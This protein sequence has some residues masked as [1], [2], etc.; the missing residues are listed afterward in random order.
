MIKKLIQL[1]VAWGCLCACLASTGCATPVQPLFPERA[2]V[3]WPKPPDEPRIAY[4]GRL[5]GEADLGAAQSLWS[6]IQS[7]VTGLEERVAFS[8]PTAVAVRGDL[9]CVADAQVGQ[10]YYLDLAARTMHPTTVPPEAT[11]SW[12][13]DVA[14]TPAGLAV[15]DSHRHEVLMF[16]EQGMFLRSFGA[17][18]LIRPGAVAWHDAAEE[19]WVLDTGGHC[20]VVFDREGTFTRRVG[21]RG[22][23]AGQFNY[24]AGLAIWGEAIVI[25]DS[26][27]FRI[28]VLDTT[29]QARV[30]FGAKG[31]AAGN[32]ALPR[33]VA[34][35]S[36]GHIYVLDSQFENIQIFDHQGQLLMAFGRE[37]SDAGQFYLP[38]GLTIDV[39]DRIWVADS[40]NRRIQV[41]K[42][43]E[44]GEASL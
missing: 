28:Q 23:S 33:D 20:C 39:R 12:P 26:M 13:I 24:P 18:D 14:W 29:G 4:V 41:F 8:V 6:G 7:A 40:Y 42:Y 35:D 17:D 34:V 36:Q 5:A 30:V 2:S 25:A 27:N 15:V 19:L 16:N 21:E 32:F 38:G 10:V 22:G 11:L 31:D 1:R 9:I 37:G 44:Q 43:L 3:M